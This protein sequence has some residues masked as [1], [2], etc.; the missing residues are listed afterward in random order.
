MDN[1]A[2]SDWEFRIYLLLIPASFVVFG[3][4]GLV[5]MSS[6]KDRSTPLTN[7][8]LSDSDILGYQKGLLER[9]CLIIC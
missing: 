7:R 3:K 2:D 4:S 5:K 1:H 9:G 8:T 6:S